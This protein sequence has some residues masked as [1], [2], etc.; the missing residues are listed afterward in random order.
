MA[1]TRPTTSVHTG[2]P[3]VKTSTLRFAVSIV[4]LLFFLQAFEDRAA[5][6]RLSGLAGAYQV[7]QHPGERFQVAR[8]SFRLSQF[9]LRSSLHI[10]T[11]CIGTDPQIQQFEDFPQRSEEHTSELQSRPHLV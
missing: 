3:A 4:H 10:T 11:A 9:G 1:W 5:L 8:F 2:Q 6:G 7:L